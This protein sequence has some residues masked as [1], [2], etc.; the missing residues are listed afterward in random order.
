MRGM[1]GAAR[2]RVKWGATGLVRATAC[3]TA[4][5]NDAGCGRKGERMGRW[6]DREA[7]LLAPNDSAVEAGCVRTSAALRVSGASMN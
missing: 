5:R 6:I 2:E 4:R 1:C 3:N 7:I